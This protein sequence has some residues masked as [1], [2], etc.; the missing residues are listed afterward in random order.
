MKETAT[1]LLL[2][3]GALMLLAGA[4]FGL[5]GQWVPAALVWIGAFGCLMAALNFKHRKKAG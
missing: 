2:A 5:I 3:A 4:I 1:R